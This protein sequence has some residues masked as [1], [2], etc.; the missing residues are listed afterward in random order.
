MVSSC[1]EV[2]IELEPFAGDGIGG[3]PAR[4][5]QV[6]F[7]RPGSPHPVFELERAHLVGAEAGPGVEKDP[8]S[9]GTVGGHE[10]S[11]DHR[12]VGVAGEGQRLPALDDPGGGDP[13]A[14][15][16]QRAVLV[17]ATPDEAAFG[18]GDGVGA[19]ATDEQGEDGVGLPLGG[20]HP[21]ELAPRPHQDAALA[22]GEERVLA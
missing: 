9:G 14:V 15:P 6:Q 13:T 7:T 3:P 22:V 10:P 16:D 20:T 12:G 1:G 8:R 4:P 5:A 18:R 19:L 17:V 2:D 11:Q 21:G